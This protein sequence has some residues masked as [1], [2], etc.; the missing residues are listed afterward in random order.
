MFTI[1][2]TVVVLSFEYHEV[3]INANSYLSIYNLGSLV[4]LNKLQD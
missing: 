4:A 1:S 2:V 3:S